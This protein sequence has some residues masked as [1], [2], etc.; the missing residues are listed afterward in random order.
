MNDPISGD[1]SIGGKRILVMAHAHPDF[2]LG[3]GEIAAYNLFRAYREHPGVEDAWFLGRAERGSAQPTGAIGLRRGN[4]YVWDQGIGD[5]HLM[6][7]AHRDSVIDGFAELLRALRPTVVHAHHYMHLGLEF[8]RVIR[9]VDPSIRIWMTL[10]E[11]MAI[12]RNNGQMIK[13]DGRTLCNR[14]SPEECRRCFP[15]HSAEDFWLRRHFFMRHFDLVD[16]FISPS[17]FLRQ[18]YIDWGIAAERIEVIENGQAGEL[19]LPPRPIGDGELR[20]R[21]GFFGQVTP[22]KGLDVVLAAL[23]QMKRKDR[24]RILLE[25]H[26]A[27]LDKQTDEYRERVEALRAPLMDEG[28]VQWVGPYQPHDLR[29]RMAGVDWVL[30]PSIWWENSPMVI[31]EAFLCGR[32]LLVSD[33]GGMAEKVRDGVDGLHV[34]NANGLAWGDALLRAASEEGLWERLRQGI[35]KPESHARIASRHLFGDYQHVPVGGGHV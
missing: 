13:T 5:W 24:R 2:S 1:G 23:A 8:L 16:R 29:R 19:P 10:H 17:A 15:R 30:V 35:N 11:Y 20:N 14:S 3:G 12:C 9:S 18:R 33:I 25:V 26:G 4:E 7:A 27:N 31:Q 22:Y 32:P 6:K 34:A 21:F 28:T